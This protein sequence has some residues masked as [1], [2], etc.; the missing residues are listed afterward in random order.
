MEG[1]EVQRVSV[2]WARVGMASRGWVAQL[3]ALQSYT[4]GPD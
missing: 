3:G 2:G 4:K 1:L